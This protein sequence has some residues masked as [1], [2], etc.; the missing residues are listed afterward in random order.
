V[1]ESISNGRVPWLQEPSCGATQC[2]GPNYAEEPGKLFRQ[3]RG[4]GGLFC[5]ACH[6]EPHAILPSS[7]ANDNAQNI[8]LQGY[9]GTLNKCEVCHGVVPTGAGPHGIN[10]ATQCCLNP[11]D[12]NHDAKV[13]VGDAVFIINYVFK[14]GAAPSCRQESDANHDGNVN[15]G[16]AVYM[17]NYIFKSGSSPQCGPAR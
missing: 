2:H 9:A 6:G 1:G 4:H 15:V 3:S 16:D 17:I 5:S 14:Q 7:Q 13:N 11:G 10:G 12:A 8:A